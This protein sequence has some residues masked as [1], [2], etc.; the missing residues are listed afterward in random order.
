[1]KFWIMS[2]SV[3][4]LIARQGCAQSDRASIAGTIKDPSGAVIPGVEVVVTQA[5]TS[6]QKS[7]ITNALGS[8]TLLNLPIG[9]YTLT[10]S[11][12]GFLR[13]E[14]FGVKLAINQVAEIDIALT[15][16]AKTEITTVRRDPSLLQTQ[17]SSITANLLN[18]ALT[19]APLNVQGGAIL[20]LSCL[21]SCR[22]W[23]E[24]IPIHTS[25]AA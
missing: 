12:D 3:M 25:T 8:Y 22:A 4:L 13:Y 5:N 14:R 16:G 15:L 1:M 20:R 10:C 11:K 18:S 9:P 6:I 2:L 7:S 24:P 17:T 21:N 23:K 19:E